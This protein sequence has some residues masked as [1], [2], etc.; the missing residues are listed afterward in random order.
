MPYIKKADRPA[1][2]NHLN[3]ITIVDEGALNYCVCKLFMAYIDS[4]EGPISYRKINGGLGAIELAKQELI[5]RIL[6]GY[7]HQK[8]IENG[9]I[10]TDFIRRHNI[11]EFS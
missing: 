4:Q 11:R 1:L 2:D 9:D 6:R 10:F 7:E 8:V 3:D 5:A